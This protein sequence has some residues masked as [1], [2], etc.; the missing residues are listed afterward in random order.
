MKKRGQVTTFMI[1][2]LVILIIFVIL[3]MLRDSILEGIKGAE[4]TKQILNG[5]VEEM[6][7]KIADCI[8]KEADA[9][10]ITL[11]KQ[12]G[13]FTLTNFRDFTGEKINY[14]CFGMPDSDKCSNSGLTRIELENELT[15][16]LTPRVKNCVNIESFRDDQRYEMQVGDFEFKTNIFDKSVLFNI[17][18]PITL[19]RKEIE[20][21]VFGFSKTVESPLGL[22]QNVVSDILNIE[23]EFG[24]FDNVMYTLS[25]K[26]EFTIIQKRPIPDTIYVI[27]H[28]DYPYEFQFA[29]KGEE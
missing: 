25:K 11:G 8:D 28:R 10:I 24:S 1:V 20:A 27:T 19:K 2:G 13:T 23:S 16:Y 9:A 17:T 26:S 18:Y 7:F 3:F 4:G 22:I 12:G 5:V 29:I 21:K 14:L 15:N 6:D